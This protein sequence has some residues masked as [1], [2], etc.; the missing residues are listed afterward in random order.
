MS[1]KPV[2]FKS[3]SRAAL[4]DLPT[5][6]TCNAKNACRSNFRDHLRCVYFFASFHLVT[7]YY[8]FVLHTGAFGYYS[9]GLVSRVK[10]LA[11]PDT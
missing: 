5:S 11:L 4:R 9:G 10:E 8:A 1:T 3:R 6:Y 2:I 7:Y